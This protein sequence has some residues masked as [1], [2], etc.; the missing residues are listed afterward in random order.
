M[1]WK[2]LIVAGVFEVAWAIGLEYSDGFSKFWPS[3]AT[4]VALVVS[5]ALLAKSLQTLPVGTAYAV[6]TGIGAV[7]T[8][9]LGIVLFDEPA[10]LLRVAFIGVIVVG[11]VGLHLSSGGH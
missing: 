10:D 3:V 6:W 7:G 9:T 1:S 11:I 4:V 2:V 8:A 5:M